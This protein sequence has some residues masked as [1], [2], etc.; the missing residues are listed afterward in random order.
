MHSSRV[1]NFPVKGERKRFGIGP[2]NSQP[3]PFLLD[4]F[5]HIQVGKF[6]LPLGR[7]G[8]DK[9]L[10]LVGVVQVSPHPCHVGW[11]LKATVLPGNHLA[12]RGE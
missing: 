7:T 5:G 1:I 9:L 8:V 12:T 3:S 11:D 6:D 4:P 2:F 10:P